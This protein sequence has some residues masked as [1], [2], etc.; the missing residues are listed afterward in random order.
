MD[1]IIRRI[2]RIPVIF[3][4]TLVDPIHYLP[5][6][7][8]DTFQN[9]FN[10]LQSVSEAPPRLLQRG[11]LR[12]AG[13]LYFYSP[14]LEKGAD[15]CSSP[16]EDVDNIGN[17]VFITWMNES[18]VI[19]SPESNIELNKFLFTEEVL[20]LFLIH[21]QVFFS[22]GIPCPLAQFRLAIGV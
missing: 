1:G 22:Q 14:G 19:D 20:L 4:P 11:L 7:T 21:D 8:G 3:D 10:I 17:L 15:P 13:L 18:D 16:S 2:L 12:I 9:N 5:P 6:T